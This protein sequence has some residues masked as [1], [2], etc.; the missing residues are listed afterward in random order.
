MEPKMD[1]NSTCRL[2]GKVFQGKQ[3]VQRHIKSVHDGEKFPCT[4]CDYKATYK[5]HIQT[6]MKSLHA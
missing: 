1:Q 3:S 6:H 5:G 2:C 4:Q